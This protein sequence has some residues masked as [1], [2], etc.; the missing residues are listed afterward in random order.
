MNA[1]N[2]RMGPDSDAS[3]SEWDVDD[4]VFVILVVCTG[5]VCRSPLAERALQAGFDDLAPGRFRISSAGTSGLSGDSVTEEITRLAA[6]A[7][8]DFDGFRA[9]R[10]V[11]GH[12]DDADLVLTMAR[13]HRSAVVVMVPSALR[14]TFTLR[15][16]ARI[17]PLVP[18]ESESDP[19]D[20]WRSLAA[21]AQRYRHPG[22]GNGVGDDVVDP[23][24]RSDGFHQRMYSQMMPAI[25]LLLDWE[26]ALGRSAS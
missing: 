10:L 3:R 24:G 5:N 22:P 7:G 23:Y 20:R 9:R 21:L 14:R 18:A 8:I 25:R 19:V 2:S 1:R 11:P 15:E 26:R 12:V 17:L 13:D 6:P 4:G 16:F